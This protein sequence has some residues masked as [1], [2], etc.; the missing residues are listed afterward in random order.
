MGSLV[1]VVLVLT[2]IVTLVDLIINHW[3]FN[4]FGAPSSNYGRP[5]Y[6]D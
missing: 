1:R 5:G 4:H 6:P 2:V 3:V